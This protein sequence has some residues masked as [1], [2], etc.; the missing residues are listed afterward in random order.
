[1]ITW[2]ATQGSTGVR[3]GRRGKAAGHCCRWQ[4]SI[5]FAACG[6][7]WNM[8]DSSPI[9]GLTEPPCLP[10]AILSQ[11]S[12]AAAPRGTDPP[13]FPNYL[14]LTEQVPVASTPP[15]LAWEAVGTG[16]MQGNAGKALITS[17]RFPQTMPVPLCTSTFHFTSVMNYD[18]ALRYIAISTRQHIIVRPY[19]ITQEGP[20]FSLETIFPNPFF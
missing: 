1:M 19:G 15:W 17:T 5:L 8:S 4:G 16:L 3:V 12:T 2:E 7:V 13:A 6:T 18:N 14:S 20:Y 9:R 10:P 11:L